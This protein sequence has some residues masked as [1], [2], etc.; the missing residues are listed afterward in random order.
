MAAGDNFWDGLRYAN[1]AGALAT[2]GFGA[3]APLPRPDAVR[4]LLSGF[5]SRVSR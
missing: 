5:A 2:T 4:R 3:V 1:A